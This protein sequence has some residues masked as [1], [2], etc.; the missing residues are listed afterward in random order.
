MLKSSKCWSAN[1]KKKK[2]SAKLCT[3]HSSLKLTRSAGSAMS[4]WCPPALETWYVVRKRTLVSKYIFII[5]WVIFFRRK[6][7]VQ[8]FSNFFQNT[9]SK[10]WSK[11]FDFRQFFIQILSKFIYR[12]SSVRIL[13]KYILPKSSVQFFPIFFLGSNCI[14]PRKFDPIFFLK[15]ALSKFIF[16]NTMSNF[17]SKFCFSKNFCP[18]FCHVF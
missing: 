15:D 14:F 9:W 18:N 12:K 7:L 17:P 13:Y 8:I 1:I 6:N 11:F 4:V 16:K 2:K 3:T 10:F 5:L